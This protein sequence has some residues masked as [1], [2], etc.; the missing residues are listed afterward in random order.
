M[1]KK[2][3]G[4]VSIKTING[5]KYYY[6]QWYENGKRKSKTI[7][8]KEYIEYIEDTNYNVNIVEERKFNDKIN[9]ITGSQL[10][11]MIKVVSAYN[12][13]IIFNDLSKYIESPYNGKVL[14]LYGLRRTGKTSLIFQSILNLND[15]LSKVAYIL[16]REGATIDKLNVALDELYKQGCKYVYID[17]ITLIKDFIEG[18]SFL[19]DVYAN[20]MKIV[21][22]G[23]DS[24]GFLIASLNQLYDRCIMVHTSYISYK[25]FSNVLNINDIDIY[26]EYG[27]TMIK[28]GYNYHDKIAPMFYDQE[29][30]LNYID[31]S[32]VHNILHSLDCY[33][34]GNNFDR[35][36]ELKYTNDLPGI[37]NRIIQDLNH[38]FLASILNKSFKS[39]D[40]GSL[41]DLMRKNKKSEYL[42]TFLDKNIDDNEIYKDLMERLNINADKY[43]IEAETLKELE[44]YLYKLEV[45]SYVDVYDID[46]NVKRKRIVFNQPGLR[47]S[48]AKGLLETL[49]NNSKVISLSQ[50]D[51]ELLLATLLNDVKGR[52][53]EDIVLLETK[54]SC[55]KLSFQA[56]FQFGEIDMVIYDRITDTC[57][58]YEIKH[59]NE[60]HKDQYRHLI[61]EEFITKIEEKYGVISKKI[62]L[63][64]GKDEIVGNVQYRNVE[65]YL[66]KM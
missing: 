64:N 42:R 36:K 43:I 57:E 51:L 46:N 39:T 3:K 56:E 61:N 20:V 28:E 23:T 27:G 25:E 26:I 2:T 7:T 5:K 8:E 34:D 40:Y 29:T 21:L 41:K 58:L 15:D 10:S 54:K 44:N 18:A 47:Y 48:L 37:I 17:E 31:A 49:L 16:V 38:R 60:I 19:S 35:L 30:T 62:V 22:S 14:I 45:I 11:E 32:I 1:T 24:L 55:A 53:L 63:Y 50:K 66:L 13:R 9:V 33:K 6:Y 65:E 52:M 59:S 4:G 12:K